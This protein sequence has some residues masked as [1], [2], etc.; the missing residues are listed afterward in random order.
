[1]KITQI[2]TIRLEEF[3]NIC[4]V[5]VHT[6]QGHIGLGETYF[7]A[8][9]VEAWIHE[10]GAPVL[11]GKDPLTIERHWQSMVG[12]IGSRSTGVEN[13]GRSALDIALWDIFGQVTKQ[14]IYQL[15]GGKCREKIKAYNTCAGYHYTRKRPKH[16]SLP[17]DN[18]GVGD[19]QGP[20]ED[21]DG[22]LYHAGDLAES[23]VEEGFMGMKIWPFDLYAEATK[24]RYI[25]PADLN[26]AL[27]PFRQ[28][29]ER[30]GNKIEIMVELHSLWDLPTAKQIAQALEEFE[31]FWYEDPINMDN[32]DAL[33]EF[34][35]STRVRTAASETLGTR[36]A[37]RDIL[38]RN[39]A[40][41]IIFDPTFTGGISEGKRIATLAETYEVPV[42]PHDCVGPVSFAVDVHLTINAPNAF[43]QECVRAFYSGWYK[44]LVTEVPVVK[45]GYVYPLEGPGL[46]TALRPEV[47][48]R[49]DMTKRVSR[50]QTPLIST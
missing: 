49:E 7:A 18:W 31:P 39:A 50:Y 23:L 28:I 19:A 37:F 41:V 6:D 1:M 32:L 38:E 12:F 16:A 34:A 33:Q 47:F 14:P 21:L 11:L 3:P 26:K 29:R 15:L 30:V 44:E 36:W 22:F 17:V 10:A 2:E 13:R 27:E 40:G 48:E 9:A 4:F 20:Y 46:G 43:V 5:Q 25:S 24:G 8:E 42:T 35:R 45:A